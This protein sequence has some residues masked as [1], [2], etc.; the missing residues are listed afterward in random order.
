MSA[1]AVRHP[2]EVR[3][4]TRLLAVITAVLVAFGVAALANAT[5]S[6][7]S[8]TAVGSARVLRQIAG[9]GFGGLIIWAAS[10]VDYRRLRDWAW[11]ILGVV[12]LMLLVVMFGPDAVAP[13]IKGASRWLRLPG[14]SLQFQPSE[15]ARVAV[16]IWC[17]MLASKKG[18]LVRDWKRGTMPF[19]VVLGLIFVLIERQPNLS[20]ALLVA[21]TGGV[22]F[23]TAGA[24]L[25]HVFSVMILGLVAVAVVTTLTGYRA[26]RV[27]NWFR[28]TS[29]DASLGV[30][31]QQEMSIRAI[32]S[33]GLTGRGYGEGLMKLGH[34]PESNTD[35]LF[36][37]I[38]EEWGFIGVALIVL[39]YA[40]FVWMGFRIARTASDTFGTYLATGLTFGIGF[41][42]FAHMC[43]DLGIFPVTGLTLPFMSSGLSSLVSNCVA[44]GILL[45]IGQA[46]GR[47]A[48]R[49]GT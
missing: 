9:V 47:L 19:L 25:G 40:T 48:P 7:R 37:T 17:A 3:W 39:F 10:L 31:Y 18:E 43:V 44:V 23:F 46:R 29:A 6:V 13:T 16:A 22:I 14:T 5:L 36:A 1:P 42:A 27:L 21:L 45:S 32:A 28:P 24:R 41:P 15:L 12:V 26:D 33:G 20:M 11:P 49:R 8:G 34:L 4:E 2:G 35:F 30:N 38:G